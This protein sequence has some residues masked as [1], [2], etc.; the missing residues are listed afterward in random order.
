MMITSTIAAAILASLL[1]DAAARS[2]RIVPVPL[3]QPAKPKLR[4]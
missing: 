2:R 1:L 4:R 3:G